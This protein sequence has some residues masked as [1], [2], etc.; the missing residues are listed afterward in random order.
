MINKFPF[1]E[2]GNNNIIEEIGKPFTNYLCEIDIATGCMVSL[3][4]SPEHIPVGG[5]VY[6]AKE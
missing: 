2:D 3:F 6:K 4:K 1:E 5:E